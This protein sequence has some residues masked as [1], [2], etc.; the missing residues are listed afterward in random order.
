M[1]ARFAFSTLLLATPAL[2]DEP[3]PQAWELETIQVEGQA[4]DPSTNVRDAAQM[5]RDNVFD[6][7]DLVRHMPGISV[8]EGGRAGSNGYAMRGVDRD[9]IA[10]TVD[11]M[12]QAEYFLPE[13]YLGY[14]YL[15]GNRNSVE[16]EHMKRVTLHKGADSYSSGSGGIGGSVQFVTKD[17]DDYVAPGR[18]AGAVGKLAYASRSREWLGMAG[19][20]VRLGTLGSSFFLQYTR[21]SGHEIKHYGG[22][23]D[24]RGGERGRP[25]PVDASTQAWLSKLDLCV[26]RGHCLQLSHDERA[27]R[28]MTDERS[29]SA[30]FGQTRVAWDHSPYKRQAVIYRWTPADGPIEFLSA[31]LHRQQV[32]QRALTENRDRDDG[33]LEQRYDRRTRQRDRRWRLETVARPW[34]SAWGSHQ[35]S[36][37]L[38]WAQRQ[39]VNDN[40]D[41][42]F[43]KRGPGGERSY[44]II[45]PVRTR[46]LSFKL[47]DAFQLGPDWSGEA[48]WRFDHYGHRPK[49]GA[50]ASAS[51]S[52][53]ASTLSGQLSYRLT[54]DMRL[55]YAVA[56]GF[57]APSAQELYFQFRRGLSAFVANPDLKAERAL[58]Q[59]ITLAS[60]GRAGAWALSVFQTQYRDFIAERHS[61]REVPN[62]YYD[63][64][65]PGSGKPTL[66]EDV[67][68]SENI[69]RAKVWGIELKGEL[70]AHGAFGAPRGLGAEV[71]AS[72]MRG[73]TGQGDGMRALQPAQLV[74]GVFFDSPRWGARADLVYHGAKRARDTLQ[75]TYS[76]RGAVR[77]PARYLS[78][79]VYL[80]DL[81]A[82]VRM[83]KH[84]TLS[85]GVYNLFDRRYHSWDTL[86]SLAEFGTTG[87]VRG[88]GLNRYT[89]PGRNVSLSLALRY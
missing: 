32:T 52:F 18:V 35:F 61:Q 45:D 44:G 16:L 81:S 67:F 73:R 46:S 15:N 41:R 70:D 84:I 11:G 29:Y 83:G 54:G 23:A 31:G 78:P 6:A 64:D 19:T 86:R 58:N 74:T 51:R 53:S 20:G 12:P 60:G 89:A 38:A 76:H 55:S 22:G 24:I 3:S 7:R 40:I 2:A 75:T 21:R 59:Q 33:F 10:V 79:A 47:M 17:I 69:D 68:R 42:L 48:G 57:R 62:V 65:R 87:R 5:S 36:G 63:P 9:R 13:V 39:L 72:F 37:E 28:R 26:V 43:F 82:Y 27:E 25:D 56:Q 66:I 77:R 14:G 1:S 8:S 88:D 4:E 50:A 71:R 80:V 49:P 85:G 34:L 30:I